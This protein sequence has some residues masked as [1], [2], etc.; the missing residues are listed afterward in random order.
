MNERLLPP[1]VDHP[2]RRALTDELHAR[3]FAPLTA[4]A[5]IAYIAIATDGA[6]RAESD[7]HLIELLAQLGIDERPEAGRNHGAWA[8]D[9]FHLRWERHT[10]F[11]SYNLTVSG[12]PESPFDAA[13]VARFPVAWLEAAPG[14]VIT[15]VLMQIEIASDLAS[16]EAVLSDRFMPHLNA[17]SVAAS[18]LAEKQALAVSDF[19]IDANGFTR[20]ALIGVEGVGPRRLGRLMQRLVELETYRT[21]AMR[22]LPA[23]RRISPE[24]REVGREIASLV[25]GIGRS[26]SDGRMDPK[27][28]RAML[29]SVTEVSAKLERLSA[30][31][32]YRF[33]ASRAYRAI[34]DERLEVIRQQRVMGRQTFSEF[35]IRRFYPAMRTCISAE[36]RLASL[37][38]RA[39][40][41]ANLLRTRVDVTLEAQNQ[42]L[43]ASMNRRAELQLRLQQTVEGLSVVAI[44]YYAVSLAGY[45]LGPLGKW[46]D[47]TPKLISAAVAV[48][49]ILI[50]WL[51]VRRLRRKAEK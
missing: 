3:P 47:L 35:M 32:A 20:F 2:E 1:S 38:V 41:A 29:Q 9:D 48:P 37:A 25:D 18:W 34:V 49:I 13:A 50:V 36:D 10:E 26:D 15:A 44:S 16:A 7:T 11:I 22:A 39:E 21:L 40:R 42:A 12:A 31:S 14:G 45:I 46:L 28:E 23:A 24:L 6:S 33:S 19:H 17:E 43:L 5:Q 8:R 27:A 51:M 4:P 30:D